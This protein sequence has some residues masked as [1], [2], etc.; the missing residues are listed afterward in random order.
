[1]A[2]DASYPTIVPMLAYADA[3]AA[4]DFLVAAFG[5]TER[6][7]MDMPDGKIGHAELTLG[8]GVLMLASV[9]EAMGF[10]SAADLP[11]LPGQLT[12]Y[13]PDVDAH[14]AQ[15][16]AAG[17][18]V[19]A[20]PENQPHGDRMYRAVDLEGNRWIFTQR[21]HDLSAEAMTEAYT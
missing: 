8:D 15:A 21:L 20:A 17:A 5:F 1:M 19:V 14:H 4:I 11:A 3:P 6:Y 12:V 16:V 10:A 9:Y 2:L 18:T 13:V 7:R